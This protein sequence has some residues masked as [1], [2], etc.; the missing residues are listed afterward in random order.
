VCPDSPEKFPLLTEEALTAYLNEARRREIAR[1]KG[2]PSASTLDFG[3]DKRAL[4][5][6][7]KRLGREKLIPLAMMVWQGILDGS[8]PADANVRARVSDSVASRF[9]L[10]R[11]TELSLEVDIAA[12]YFEMG[13]YRDAQGVWH[14]VPSDPL[15][16]APA[17]VV[18]EPKNGT[19]P[20]EGSNGHEHP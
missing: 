9:G 4:E 1:R 7:A 10:P 12:K 16:I 13:G 5:H 2:K 20:D 11:R 19:P 18:D 15:K 3:D 14:E 6:E 8:I 17:E